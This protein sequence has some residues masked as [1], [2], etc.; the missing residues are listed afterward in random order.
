MKQHIGLIQERMQ[1]I[2]KATWYRQRFDACPHFMFFLGDAH[3]SSIQDTTYPFGQRLAY[4]GFSKNRADW[5][6]SLEELTYTA[7]QM[8]E[9]A[10]HD[11]DVSQK[12]VQAFLPWQEQ[13]Y[14]ACAAIAQANRAAWSTADLRAAYEQLAD[15]YTKKLN[16]SPL[17]DGFSLST[18]ALIASKIKEHL[19]TR[20]MAHSFV[21]SF[22]TL[23]AP[24][25]TSFLQEE[26][27]AL[28]A[29]AKQ[30]QADPSQR[31][32]LI[33]A[34][35]DSFFWIQN[36]YVK[37]HML[38][39]AFFD[40]RLEKMLGEKIDERI[41]TIQSLATTHRAE[42][43]ALIHT[44]ELPQELI[45]LLRITDDMN[46]WQDE[47]KKG[48]F[49]AT[50]YFS[51]LLEEIAN[52][53]HY[54]LEQL[55]YAF[56]PEIPDILAERIDPAELDRR[57]EYCI[58]F[59][60]KDIYDVT[61]DQTLIKT[62]DLIGTGN[63]SHAEGQSL[64]GFVASKGITQGRACILE[65]VEEINK[66]QE[67]DIVVAVMT[68]PD[69]LPAMQKAAAFVT[70]EGGITCHAAIVAREMKKPCIIGTKIATKVIKDGDLVEVDANKGT[71]TV[72]KRA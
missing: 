57:I 52:R 46:A 41:A 26:E 65:S 68:R 58:I 6:H 3:I 9:A 40:A 66:V 55:K 61:T 1:K 23:T 32:A 16:A 62:L 53:T 19:E 64:K 59:W 18:D 33:R 31:Q 72:L 37:D 13:F 51:L 15:I 36:N 8:I 56:P 24:V 30:V 20:G 38:D 29:I 45:T 50:H 10:T 47:R 2:E 44:L 34:H 71:V 54:T 69:Y 28:L 42:K 5:Y 43:D 11:P 39:E 63:T 21:E 67:G 70:D 49:W 25:F 60:E 14:T 17:I 22:A 27:I 4:A 48:T 35:R 7:S 12:I